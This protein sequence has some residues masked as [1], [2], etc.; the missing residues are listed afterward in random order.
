MGNQAL[1]LGGSRTVVFAT[2]SK[3]SNRYAP[4]PKN[5]I[6][7]EKRLDHKDVIKMNTRLF[8]CSSLLVDLFIQSGGEKCS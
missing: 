8:D 7:L 6:S 3:P 2:V 5:V 1:A 4:R